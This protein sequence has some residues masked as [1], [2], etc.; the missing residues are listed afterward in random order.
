MTSMNT[1][2][3]TSA[4]TS[5]D[6]STNTS[7]SDSSSDRIERVEDKDFEAETAVVFV[8]N[9]NEFMCERILCEYLRQNEIFVVASSQVPGYNERSRNFRVVVKQCDLSKILDSNLW[10]QGVTISVRDN[11]S[12]QDYPP[13][14]AIHGRRE[15]NLPG[16]I[17]TPGMSYWHDG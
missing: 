14:E 13:K 15:V 10:P 4:N 6:T 16:V 7:S 17:I 3:D 8:C 1:S 11:T 9:L 12:N 2:T 5:T